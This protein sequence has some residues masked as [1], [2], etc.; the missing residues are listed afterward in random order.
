MIDNGDDSI[1]DPST[2]LMWQKVAS[3][4]AKTWEEA[5]SYCKNLNLGGYSDWRLPDITELIS[6]VQRDRENP[7][8]N[9][10]L[11]PNTESDFHWSSTAD[12]NET[13]YAWGVTFGYGGEYL[14]NKNHK[15]FLRA[16]RG[17]SEY[18]SDESIA[19]SII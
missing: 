15:F 10:Q 13:N 5:L 6:L 17:E 14:R 16:V 18:H 2:G 7:V 1:T 3:P 11:F 8:I 12:K 19:T 4:D 9:I